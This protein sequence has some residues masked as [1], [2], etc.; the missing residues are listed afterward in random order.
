[1]AHFVEG[2]N[3]EVLLALKVEKSV[4]FFGGDAEI[5]NMPI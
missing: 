3:A 5:N 2:L 1:V 4:N